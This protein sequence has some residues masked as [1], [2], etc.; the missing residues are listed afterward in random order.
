MPQRT[1]CIQSEVKKTTGIPS[2]LASDTTQIPCADDNKKKKK[3][4]KKHPEMSTDAL[5]PECIEYERHF[6]M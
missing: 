4:K 3:K 1:N 2:V 6:V 5:V